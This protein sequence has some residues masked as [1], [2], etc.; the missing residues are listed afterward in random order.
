MQISGLKSGRVAFVCLLAV[1]VGQA[2]LAAQGR[3]RQWSTSA[4]TDIQITYDDNPFLLDTARMT[5]LRSPSS[6]DVASGRFKD[7]VSVADQIVTPSLVFGAK[8]PGLGRRSLELRGEIAYEFN[9]Q[10][11]R[12]KHA[13][14][15]FVL[16]HSVTKG[17]QLRFDTGW[18]T[19]AFNKN[20]LADAV[21]LNVDGNITPDERRY[22]AALVRQLDLSLGYRQ[23]LVKA[24]KHRA[25]G[26]TGELAGTY[27]DKHYDD[28]FSGRSLTGPGGIAALDFELGRRWTLGIN[29]SYA[30]LDA[31]RILEVL[32]LDE[33]AFG[34]DLNGNGNAT[35]LNARTVQMVDRSRKEQHIGATL[36]SELGKRVT[37]KLGYD[38]RTRNFTSAEPFD[39]ADNGRDDILNELAA[40][41][42]FELGRA[43]ELEI[44]GKHLKQTT[45]RAG[46]PA[47]TGEVADYLRN[48]ASASLSYRF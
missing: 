19:N 8:G 14:L 5:K 17:G 13:D 3:E 12:R 38:R 46:D 15:G 37:A 35:D 22:A 11:T 41:L 39:V 1:G 16:Q 47:S 25:F 27:G 33:T 32:L 6:G 43:I 20:Y 36:E 18:Q 45:N 24:T 48:V 44:A 42:K 9:I 34:Q 26:L 21:D 10:N 7:M 4:R 31:N 30:E 40:A 2:P 23:R 29:Y 28:P